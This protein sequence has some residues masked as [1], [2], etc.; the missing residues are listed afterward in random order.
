MSVR[1]IR[2]FA[3]ETGRLGS[4]LLRGT[5]EHR[6]TR[7]AIPN[8]RIILR[9]PPLP[10]LPRDTVESRLAVLRRLRYASVRQ[11]QEA[12]CLRVGQ[13]VTPSA[14]AFS[15]RVDRVCDDRVCREPTLDRA[16]IESIWL[17]MR[18]HE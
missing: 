7:P 12:S 16:W 10:D 17:A 18:A 2:L 1:F 3:C 6:F 14:L 9:A 4:L 8:R 13:I 11:M 5:R 15:V